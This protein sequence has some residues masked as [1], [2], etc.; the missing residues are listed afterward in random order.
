MAEL[1]STG[2][3]VTAAAVAGLVIGSFLN[4][5]IHR[6]PKMLERQWQN[7]AAAVRG[8]PPA[9]DGRYDLMMP[10]SHCPACGQTL[11]LRDLIPVASWLALGARCA[12]CRAP[13]GLRYP[14]IEITTAV[15]FALCVMRFDP[16]PAA[17]AAMLL[18]SVL[19]AA[20][21]IDYD[22]QLLP[23]ALTLPLLWAG[24]LVNLHAL[25]IP[26]DQ[27]VL[28]AVAGYVSLW[29]VHHAFRLATGR[30]GMGYGDFKLLAAI[31]AWLGWQP[32]APVVLLA[33]ASGAAFA[34]L[35]GLAGLRDMRAPIAFGPWLAAAGMIALF[36]QPALVQGLLG[37]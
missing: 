10:R 35:G 29:S 37:S 28:G 17:L 15:L 12:A 16:A 11:R 30:E 1:L 24:L 6:L 5:V 25:F 3:A 14:L 31:G 18:A 4:V 13:I 26:I 20:A 32:L 27:A 7:D 2:W 34:I 23:D 21:V 36:T 9:H 19:L 8:D 22:T 33:C